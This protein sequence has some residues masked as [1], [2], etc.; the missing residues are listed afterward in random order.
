MDNRITK[1]RL[2]D[3]LSY[4]WILIVIIVVVAMFVLELVYTVGSV[5]LTTGQEFKIYYDENLYSDKVDKLYNLMDREK[6]LSY[7][8]LKSDIEALTSDYNVLGVRL[9][10]QEGD[11][12]ITDSIEPSED[13]EKTDVR[14]K[15]VIDTNPVYVLDDMLKDAKSYL[16]SFLTDENAG[17]GAELEFS[18][19]STEK[20]NQKFL[21]RMKK[22]N[23]F[24][25]D[26][27]KADGLVLE[28][29]RIEKL[30]SD[31]KLFEYYLNNAPAEA[32][33]SYTKYEQYKGSESAGNYTEEYENLYQKEIDEGRQNA[34]YGLN[35]L[36]LKTEGK[37]DPS[38]YFKVRNQAD[39]TG[40]V[41]MAFNFLKYQPE[42]QFECISLMSTLIREFTNIVPV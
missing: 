12:I 19:L 32:F 37:T 2:T 18:N 6:T 17:P 27:Q 1:K 16:R 21:A 29:E 15:K 14:A 24:R 30:C 33:Y 5:R 34:R 13:S 11:I 7:D 26:K 9:S 25:S 22:D 39:S 4:E 38:D 40:V 41:I 10:V 31:V 8:V 3:Y 42:L 23:R 28:C 36:A 35:V 20:I